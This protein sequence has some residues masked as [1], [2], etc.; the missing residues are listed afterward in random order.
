M[1]GVARWS[2]GVVALLALLVTSILIYV[3]TAVHTAVHTASSAQHLPDTTQF[4]HENELE[5]EVSERE[6]QETYKVFRMESSGP[7][8]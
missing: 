5:S 8:R 2:L 3:N 1:K 7:E 4:K 6:D